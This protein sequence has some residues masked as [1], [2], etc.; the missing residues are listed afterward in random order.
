[1]RNAK[2]VPPANPIPGGTDNF[3]AVALS[4]LRL[5]CIRVES[6]EQRRLKERLF[7]TV[8]A[9]GAWFGLTGHWARESLLP[10]ML[11]YD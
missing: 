11:L 6:N 8:S 10:A 1:M 5:Y 7:A 3:H 9:A 2:I 4:I